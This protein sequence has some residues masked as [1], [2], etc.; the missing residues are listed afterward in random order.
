MLL[1]K[2]SLLIL[3]IGLFGLSGT[4]SAETETK[5][6]P[7]LTSPKVI[8]RGPILYPLA[9]LSR[10]QEGWVELETMVDRDGKPYDIVVVDAVGHSAFQ[11]AAIRSLKKTTFEP[12]EYKGEKVDGVHRFKV[13]FSIHGDSPAYFKQFRAGFME[14]VRAIEAGDQNDSNSRLEKLRE[15]TKTLYEDA[16]YW[17]A[18]FYLERKWGTPTQQLSSVNRALGYNETPRYMDENLFENLLWSKLELQIQLGHYRESLRTINV[19]ERLE[20]LD[21]SR[22]LELQQY[23]NSIEELRDAD[24][25]YSVNGLLDEDGKWKYVLLRNQFAVTDVSG[26]INEFQLYCQ[27]ELLR[28]KFEPELEYRLD[29]T[30]GTCSLWA[31]GKPSTEFKF[32][33]L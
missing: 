27:R 8:K 12:G 25:T 30:N 17:T 24:R 18:R 26:V 33:Q 15:R 22:K 10:E 14:T 1:M 28:F 9:A 13:A 4:L 20:E 21:E 2:P 6:I 19:L 23:R 3:G 7:T 31:I 11:R 5:E 32:L 16:M 29:G